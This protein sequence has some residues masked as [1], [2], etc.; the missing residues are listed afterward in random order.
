MISGIPIK[1]HY[2]AGY[3]TKQSDKI[4]ESIEHLMD[5]PNT[6]RSVCKTHYE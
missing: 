2:L 3:F 6:I 4:V 5:R 1:G